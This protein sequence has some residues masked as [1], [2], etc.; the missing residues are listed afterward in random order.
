MTAKQWAVLPAVT[1]GFWL[2]KLITT[3]TGEALSD[4]LV[5]SWS[6]IGT[7][8]ISGIGFALTLSAQLQVNWYRPVVY[9]LPAMFLAIFGTLVADGL[10]GIGL[11]DWF[12]TALF[13]IL[14]GLTFI[15]WWAVNKQVDVHAPDINQRYY[16]LVVSWTFMLGTALG[17]A[18]ASVGHMGVFGAG[19][20]LSVALIGLIIVEKTV[21]QPSLKILFFWLAYILTRPVGASWADYFS[22]HWQNGILGSGTLSVLGVGAF[23]I[24]L[25]LMSW[26]YRQRVGTTMRYD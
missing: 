26:R 22:Y 8:V 20:M 14:L 17:D 16:W 21:T 23:V 11:P 25:G 10:H 13:T 12:D 24:G 15:R 7:L 6:P 19:A 18:L 1:I 3:G 5:H 2:V 4:F 9:W